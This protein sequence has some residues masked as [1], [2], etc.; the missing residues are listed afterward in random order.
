MTTVATRLSNFVASQEG[1]QD[2]IVSIRF[3]REI[4]SALETAL[5]ER[6]AANA[7]VLEF[8][9]IVTNEM[10]ERACMANLHPDTVPSDTERRKMRK[11][12][13]AANICESC[14]SVADH[15]S[16]LLEAAE[17]RAEEL[18]K[19]P[20]RWPQA[21]RDVFEIELKINRTDPMEALES[22]LSAARAISRTLTEE[23]KQ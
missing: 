13:E 23:G 9:G 12:L 6:D 4:Q 7:F 8:R 19:A 14:A 21:V 1:E 20:T 17:A 11:S 10:V 3:L 15:L 18:Q 16:K 22:A 5:T 2:T